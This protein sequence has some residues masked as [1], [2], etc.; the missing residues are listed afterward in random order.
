MNKRKFSISRLINKGEDIGLKKIQIIEFFEKYGAEAARDAFGVARS[1]LFL[2]KKR[3]REG[4][5][6][7]SVLLPRSRTP[8]RHRKAEWHPEIVNYI[9]WRREECPRLGQESLKVDLADFCKRKGIKPVSATTIARII[10]WLKDRGEI[11]DLNAKV[12]LYGKT[13]KMEVIGRKKKKPR[14]G[15]FYPTGPGDLVEVDTIVSFINGVKFYIFSAIDVVTRFAFA[16]AYPKLS[17]ANGRDFLEKLLMVVP[18]EIKRVQTD[19]G[20]EFEGEFARLL[21]KRGIVH[22]YTYPRDPQSNGHIERFNRTVEEHFIE[23]KADMVSD[24]KEFNRQLMDYLIWY[25]T[26]KPHSALDR[27][28]PLA[29]FLGC[30]IRDPVESNMLWD[31]TIS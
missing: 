10:R 31:S 24:V 17:S 2:W 27:D 25:N 20:S 15:R 11:L 9:K 28:A 26:K 21:R 14:K 1:T 4:S 18:F 5:N 23:W 29:Y 16:L 22:F 12:S 6:N 7:P 13:G 8:R 19:N 30:Y 3:L